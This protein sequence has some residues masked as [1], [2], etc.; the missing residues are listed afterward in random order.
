MFVGIFVYCAVA[1]IVVQLLIV[2]SKALLPLW[3]KHNPVNPVNKTPA[4]KNR[5]FA[6]MRH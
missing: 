6:V 3:R 5:Q 1:V 4:E 2:L